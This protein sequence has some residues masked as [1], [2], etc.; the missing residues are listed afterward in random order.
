[1]STITLTLPLT[2]KQYFLKK[3]EPG[4]GPGPEPDHAFY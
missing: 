1:M 3:I 4:P 2:L